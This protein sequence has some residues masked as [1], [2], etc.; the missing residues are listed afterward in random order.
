MVG[1]TNQPPASS[2]SAATA[3]PATVVTPSACAIAW[4]SCT[5][6]YC[7]SVVIGP[8]IWRGAGHDVEGPGGEAAVDRHARELEQARRGELGRLRHHHVPGRQRRGRGARGLVD[9]GVPGQ[10]DAHHAE[11]LAPRV[12]MVA[13]AE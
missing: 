2:R 4:Y 8:S 1:C 5:L 3:P 13:R 9:G 6:R 11:G 7:A 12:G 10:D